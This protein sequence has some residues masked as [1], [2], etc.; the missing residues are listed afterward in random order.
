MIRK[1]VL[2]NASF[3]KE[4]KADKITSWL[5]LKICPFIVIK[6]SKEKNKENY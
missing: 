3:S 5:S 1:Q 2:R 4:M 6:S